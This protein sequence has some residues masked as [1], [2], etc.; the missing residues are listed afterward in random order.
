VRPTPHEMAARLSYL[1]WESSPDAELA[2]AA[3]AGELMSVAS[4][5]EQAERMLGELGA[6]RMM[7]HFHRQWLM[8]DRL[9]FMAPVSDK[10]SSYRTETR[11]FVRRVLFQGEGTLSALLTDTESFVDEIGGFVYGGPETGGSAYC[12]IPGS[13][14]FDHASLDPE[15]RAG[16]LTQPSVLSVHSVGPSA[17]KSLIRR[18]VFVLDR[19]LCDPLPPPPDDVPV[20]PLDEETDLSPPDLLAQHVSDPACAGCHE[21]IDPVG[22]TPTTTTRRW[23]R[24]PF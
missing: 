17:A 3:D 4:V 18:G 20:L 23:T 2:A 24:R 5:T 9:L 11:L 15:Q 12:W 13:E 19:M 6:E 7:D 14:M 21:M 16:V 22:A 10:F 8:L 1:L